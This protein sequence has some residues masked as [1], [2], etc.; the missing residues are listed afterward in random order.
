MLEIADTAYQFKISAFGKHPAFD[1]FFSIQVE[2]PITRALVAWI[3]KA[4]GQHPPAHQKATSCSYRFWT[5][6][7]KNYDLTLG[8][9]RDSSDRMG[10]PYP[11]LIT[12]GVAIKNWQKTWQDI[13]SIFEPVFRTFE[14]SAAGRHDDF[15]SFETE[16]RNI[17][18]QRVNA[19]GKTVDKLPHSILAFYKQDGKENRLS[20]PVSKLLAAFE[21][22][23][24]KPDTWGFFKKY[25]PIPG[26]VFLGGVPDMPMIHM[27]NRPLRAQDFNRLFEL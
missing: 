27:F 13:F 14:A 7:I 26:A 8:L 20:L 2:S 12:A 17:N 6:G 16:L 4:V 1:D 23:G 22:T 19:P 21:N 11:L 3:E 25:P 10:R 15:K 24:V 9:V 18:V 5:K